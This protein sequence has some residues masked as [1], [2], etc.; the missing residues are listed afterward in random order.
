MTPRRPFWK[1][2]LCNAAFTLIELLMVVSIIAIL[3]MI[4]VPNFLEAQVRSKV[5]RARSDMAV[6]EAAI[7][8][9]HADHNAWPAN[10]PSLRD[11]LTSCAALGTVNAC[12]L[13]T[14]DG[15]PLEWV[16]PDP[17]R[18]AR[19]RILPPRA[20][21]PMIAPG[22]EMAP[23]FEFGGYGAPA[24]LRSPALDL[25]GNDLAVLTTPVAYFGAPLPDDP[26]Q[27]HGT[28]SQ[29]PPAPFM[30]LAF[31]RHAM[32]TVGA[33]WALFS[34]GPD[35]DANLENPLK[36]PWVAFDPT[37]GTVSGGDILLFGGSAPEATL[38]GAMTAGAPPPMP[39]SPQ[40][41]PTTC[42]RNPKPPGP[43][44]MPGMPYGPGPIEI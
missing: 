9:Y 15:A 24:P 26:F 29:R 6:V 41:T 30:Y 27:Y 42:T 19:S 35:T 23:G 8:A 14:P 12:N 5:A 34:A 3:A 4:C 37:N 1:R 38:W 11:M 43:G 33:R 2:V 17:S 28:Q 25:S 20:L 21:S 22:G 18:D 32:G 13:P 40:D 31:P 10:N 39:G 7:R 16:T 44:M 36:G